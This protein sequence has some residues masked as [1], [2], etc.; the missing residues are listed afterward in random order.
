MIAVDTSS[1][2][3]YLAGAPGD[4]VTLVDEA[5]EA[6]RVV[7]PP[8]VLTELA[9]APGRGVQA[10]ALVRELPM[11]D[12]T[13]G[14]WERAGVLRAG[15]LGRGFKS[16]LGDALIAQA[17]IDHDVALITADRDFRHFVRL[18]LRVLP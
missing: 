3:R 9:S 4:D 6:R 12:L 17:C 11:L 18:G 2:A 10:M 14:F 16:R 8:M 1:L 15:V 5:L 7:L 13:E